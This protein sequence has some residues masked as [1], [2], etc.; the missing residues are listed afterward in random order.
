M[1]INTFLSSLAGGKSSQGHLATESSLVYTLNS[2]QTNLNFC[3]F[4]LIVKSLH[5]FRVKNII[6]NPTTN[7][8]LVQLEYNCSMKNVKSKLGNLPATV[9]KVNPNISLDE[10]PT[11]EALR[12]KFRFGVE[13]TEEECNVPEPAK[14]RKY[15][16]VSKPDVQVQSEKY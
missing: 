12:S 10:L 1:D 14:K 3:D 15:K 2:D 5:S 8:V 9:H 6:P 11:L 16:S 7:T 13:T 4:V